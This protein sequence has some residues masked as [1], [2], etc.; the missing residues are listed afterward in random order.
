MVEL[1][2]LTLTFDV[3]QHHTNTLDEGLADKFHEEGS[4]FSKIMEWTLN[5]GR[6]AEH[7]L[8][9]QKVQKAFDEQHAKT[10][11]LQ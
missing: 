7:Y 6:I 10:Q 11:K 2:P 3:V 8:E 4:E 5:F 1:D 9:Q